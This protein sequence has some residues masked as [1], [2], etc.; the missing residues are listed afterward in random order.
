MIQQTL[1]VLMQV[2]IGNP[3]PQLPAPWPKREM[4]EELGVFAPFFDLNQYKIYET[5]VQV[6]QKGGNLAICVLVDCAEAPSASILAN[7]K[8]AAVSETSER[9]HRNTAF[10]VLLKSSKTQY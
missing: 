2:G 6:M 3:E 4:S 7:S 8:D 10:W 1:N 9:R 5:F